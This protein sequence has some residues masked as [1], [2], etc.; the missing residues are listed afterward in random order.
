MS[1]E[2]WEP[3][4]HE[5]RSRVMPFVGLNNKI[6]ASKD[7]VRGLLT[8]EM[9][10]YLASWVPKGIKDEKSLIFLHLDVDILPVVFRCQEGKGLVSGSWLTA[11]ERDKSSCRET[12][13]AYKCSNLGWRMALLRL[14][15]IHSL[16]EDNPPEQIGCF[17]SVQFFEYQQVKDIS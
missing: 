8:M 16:L 6:K 1:L 13:N 15:Y 10:I 9:I 3:Q 14:W 17:H 7:A 11:T 2:F 5:K 4:M 12:E